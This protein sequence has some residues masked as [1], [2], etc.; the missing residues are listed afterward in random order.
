MLFNFLC[1]TFCY[2]CLNVYTIN[3]IINP[4]IHNCQNMQ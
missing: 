3:N 1:F 4:S 2:T